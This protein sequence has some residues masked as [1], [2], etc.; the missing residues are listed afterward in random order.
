MSSN[1][2][3]GSMSVRWF[4][5]QN[6]SCPGKGTSHSPGSQTFPSGSPLPE[7][8]R[9]GVVAQHGRLAH[10]EGL[11]ISLRG[12]P[13]QPVL[14]L[15]RLD[16]FRHVVSG[17]VHQPADRIRFHLLCGERHEERLKPFGIVDARIEPQVIR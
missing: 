15:D 7:E 6:H 4:G 13:R 3:S 8:S 12:Q 11:G 16:A 17:V 1:V 9:L 5:L 2:G 10:E 14:R